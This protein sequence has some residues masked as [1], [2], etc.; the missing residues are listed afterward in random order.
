MGSRPGSPTKAPLRASGGATAAAAAAAAAAT[1]AATAAALDAPEAGPGDAADQREKDRDD[2]SSESS[3]LPSLIYLSAV[4]SRTTMQSGTSTQSLNSAGS[5]AAA[6]VAA[7][8]AAAGETGDVGLPSLGSLADVSRAS[9]VPATDDGT[10]VDADAKA[11]VATPEKARGDAGGE[12]A[13]GPASGSGKASPGG[14]RRSRSRAFSDTFSSLAMVS[15]ASPATSPVRQ[16]APGDDAAAAAAATPVT[17]SPSAGPGDNRGAAAAPPGAT[18]AGAGGTVSPHD[19]SLTTAPSLMDASPSR[20]TWTWSWTWGA[21]PVKF[22]NAKSEP[23][24]SSKPAG[25][26]DAGDA[27]GNGTGDLAAHSQSEPDMT[28]PG[29]EEEGGVGGGVGGS[30][31]RPSPPRGPGSPS[32]RSRNATPTPALGVDLDAQL[33][34]V[35]A[36]EKEAPPAAAAATVE[37]VALA[38]TLA[39]AA[40]EGA[41]AAAAEEV[42]EGA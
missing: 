25:E 21:L 13:G 29:D 18:D 16:L 1:A 36:L 41:A 22:R 39:T 35:W 37:T 28:R 17:R 3:M 23:S 8:A 9:S 34:T 11:A 14:L 2:V 32:A 42:L 10:G 26:G 4:A 40:A 27:A 20:K 5:G 24:M 12:P 19:T 33:A 15:S 7:A 6:A 31:G 38:A 30:G